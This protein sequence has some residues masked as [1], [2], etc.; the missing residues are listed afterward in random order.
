[1]IYYLHVAGKSVRQVRRLLRNIYQPHHYY[2]IHVDETSE[3]MHQELRGLE[4]WDNIRLFPRRYR[5]F[6]GSNSILF[7]LLLGIRDTPVGDG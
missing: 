1:M 2:Y 3:Y 5:A 6:W 4:A 7:V